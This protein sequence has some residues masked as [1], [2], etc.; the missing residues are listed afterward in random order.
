MKRLGWW[1]IVLL[2]TGCASGGG[3]LQMPPSARYCL[4]APSHSYS[5]NQ[6]VKVTAPGVDEWA[7][8]QVEAGAQQQTVWLMS[9][10]GQPLLSALWDGRRWHSDSVLG[11]RAERQ[12]A[13]ML[14]LAQWLH[15]PEAEVLN[16]F[17]DPAVHWWHGDAG[18]RRLMQGEHVLLDVSVPNPGQEISRVSL[19]AWGLGLEL[20]DLPDQGRAQ[21]AE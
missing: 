4:Q 12:G 10:L 7:V 19:P 2:L 3:C 21:E 11:W 18:Q 17:A 5:A 6:W 15:L 20:E 14:A 13:A 1:W 9:P 16:G 8:L